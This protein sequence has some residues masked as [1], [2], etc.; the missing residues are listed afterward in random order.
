MVLLLL[1]LILLMELP[2]LPLQREGLMGLMVLTGAMAP[3]LAL[4]DPQVLKDL[5]VVKDPK[6]Q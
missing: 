4:S 1:P 5:K 3:P 6:D 2:S